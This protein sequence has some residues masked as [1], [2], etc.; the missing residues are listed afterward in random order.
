MHLQPSVFSSLVQ[1]RNKPGLQ[2][3]CGKEIPSVRQDNSGLVPRQ[4]ACRFY[5]RVSATDNDNMFAIRRFTDFWTFGQ[6]FWGG[7]PT[8]REFGVTARVV[9]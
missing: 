1:I 2:I 8:P 5:C 3:F 9:F 7:L 4:L 6:G